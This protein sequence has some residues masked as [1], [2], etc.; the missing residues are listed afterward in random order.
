MDDLSRFCC[1]N[2]D[3]RD[4]G[5]RGADNLTVCMRYGKHQHLRLLYC[6]SCKARFSERQGTPLFG[7]KLETAKMV[8]VLDHVSE[9]CG[10]RKTSRL[11]GV[12]RDTVSRYSL[13]AGEHAQDLHDV[14]VAFSPQTR[15]VQFDEK[16]AFVGKKQKHC[17]PGD[18]ADSE[19]GDNWDHVAFDPT[20]RLMVS[21]VPG[22][23]TAV[24]TDALVKDVHMRTGGRLLDLLVSDEYPAYKPAILHTY[25][26]TITPPRT[27]KPGRPKKPYTVAPAGLLYATVHKTRYKGR[28]VHVEPRIVF[29]EE[30]AV[31]A[32]LAASPVSTALNTAFV[33]RHHGTDRNRNG[34]KVRKTACFSK[35]WQVHNA[36]TYFTMYSYNFCWPVR[37]LRVPQ[38]AGGWQK[39]TPAM[40][41]GLADHVWS[42][43]EWLT[44]PVVQLK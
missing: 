16:W 31:G 20:H 14:L 37:T 39:R 28:V 34:R 22:K 42:L 44:F 23:R 26:E 12:H 10:V 15:E 1:H 5:Q 25:G 29:G 24:K 38:T 17:D 41:A 40:A 9:G 6:R 35:D 4:H 36:V 7:A 27:G 13:L 8:S 21:V 32:A 3:C 43:T 18:P 33:E 2:Q 30:D 19:Q 11:I